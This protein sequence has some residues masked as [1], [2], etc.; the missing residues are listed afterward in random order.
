MKQA[1]R[2]MIYEKGF[3]KAAD[4]VQAHVDFA[5]RKNIQNI[6]DKLIRLAT[7]AVLCDEEQLLVEGLEDIEYT[8]DIYYKFIE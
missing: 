6:Q 5:Y 4:L 2:E 7:I 3:D 1:I 8:I